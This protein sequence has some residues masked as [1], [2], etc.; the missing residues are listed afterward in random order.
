MKLKGFVLFI[1]LVACQIGHAQTGQLWSQFSLIYNP[2]PKWKLST[3]A[4]ARY[5]L[6]KN[7]WQGY[8]LR[9]VV[10]YNIRPKVSLVMGSGYYFVD[11]STADNHKEFRVWEGVQARW[12][13]IGPWEFTHYVRLEQRIIFQGL[14]APYVTRVRYKI[15]GGMPVAKWAG[16]SGVLSFSLGFEPLVLLNTPFD[17]LYAYTHRYY[18]GLGARLNSKWRVDLN[19]ISQGFKGSRKERYHHSY[20]I[21]FLKLAYAI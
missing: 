2:T 1:L 16:G 20:D 12:P 8:V 18:Y 3:D 15:G 9:E 7:G 4:F 19:Y 13:K 11:F 21:A 17:D 6:V 5:Q 14:N 10:S